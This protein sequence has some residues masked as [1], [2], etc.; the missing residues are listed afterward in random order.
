MKTMMKKCGIFAAVLLVMAALM[1]GCST[2]DTSREEEQLLEGYGLVKISFADTVEQRA[3]ILP[4]TGLSL[5]DFTGGFTLQFTP[6]ALGDAKSVDIPLTSASSPGAISLIAGTYT[7][8]V[9]A[10]KGP[11]KTLA[12][13][14]YSQANIVIAA[15][16]ANTPVT[17]TLEALA[18]GKGTGTF[19]YTITNSI[20][21]T[22]VISK[23]DMIISPIPSGTA[24]PSINLDLQGKATVIGTATLKSGYYYVDFEL[25]VDGKPNH[26]RHILHVYQNLDSTFIYE[27][28]DTHFSIGSLIISSITYIDYRD[29]NVYI[30]PTY[31]T[32]I[33]TGSIFVGSL[34]GVADLTPSYILSVGDTAAPSEINI[35]VTNASKFSTITGRF[36]TTPVTI[37]GV[38]NDTF[39]LTAGVSPVEVDPVPYQFIITGTTVEDAS[40]PTAKQ[41]SVE[42]FILVT[43]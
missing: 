13:A 29:S 41:F 14:G 32:S 4:S 26:F 42:I 28:K 38:G 31:T 33:G 27:F 15:G 7:L 18:D 34:P 12:A 1:T 37:G 5:S 39:T 23:S 20:T 36:G 40:N 43:P 21:S 3:T 10:Y 22:A 17:I 9:L 30:E 35:K 2:P 25:I 16:S 19:T 8:D 24:E 11:G 6:T